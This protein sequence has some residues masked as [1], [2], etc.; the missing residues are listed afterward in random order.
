MSNK[1]TTFGQMAEY[2]LMNVE[3]ALNTKPSTVQHCKRIRKCLRFL[4]DRKLKDIN[5]DVIV[6][7]VKHRRATAKSYMDSSCKIEIG[8]IVEIL[9]LSVA[10]GYLDYEPMLKKHPKIKNLFRNTATTTLRNKFLSPEDTQKL[11][12]TIEGQ[13]IKIPMYLCLYAGL[14]ISEAINLR[15]CD[16]SVNTITV[17]AYVGY[18]PKTKSGEREIPLNLR[19][20]S[21]LD[22]WKTK[23]NK[24]R[25]V[26]GEDY[27]CSQDERQ[28]KKYSN[29]EAQ[30]QVKDVFNTSGLSFK[31]R[32]KSHALR[33]SYGVRRIV[34]LNG[35]VVQLRNEL[36]HSSIVTTNMY[37][38]E[39]RRQ[40]VV[41]QIL[42]TDLH[43]CTRA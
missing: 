22:D 14:R 43:A 4:D 3:G 37:L 17:S 28:N 1:L 29:S 33:H 39:Y 13:N 23:C 32:G 41:N 11:L 36:G 12:F 18:E 38:T 20:A 42:S 31:G 40:T 10:E 26:K 2:W 8:R 25:P 34:E 24:Y 15:W 16:V 6:E 21:V 19:L 27:V 30:E 9:R 7:Y 5:A 35:D